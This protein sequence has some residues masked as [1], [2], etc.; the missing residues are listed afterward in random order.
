MLP[1]FQT[2]VSKAGFF[3]ASCLLHWFPQVHGWWEGQPVP[4]SLQADSRNSL[5]L[6]FYATE[7]SEVILGVYFGL[8]YSGWGVLFAL[9][10]C[11]VYG[12]S[13]RLRKKS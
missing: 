12:C 4:Y 9:P 2:Y 6:R 10:E 1:L 11:R 5:L 7:N 3:R 13:L 8:P